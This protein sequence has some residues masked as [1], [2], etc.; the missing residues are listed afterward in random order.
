M[1]KEKLM[2]GAIQW[3]LHNN[4]YLVTKYRFMKGPCKRFRKIQ[5]LKS[6]MYIY[7][8]LWKD[9]HLEY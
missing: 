3:Y 9:A 1:I 4:Q 6:A 5:P 7:L 8:Q 2:Q